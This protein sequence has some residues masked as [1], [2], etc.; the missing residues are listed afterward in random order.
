MGIL[1]YT[2][3]HIL[4]LWHQTTIFMTSH[5]LYL[6]A[7]PLYLCHHIQYIDDIT[8]T[9]FLRS[10][11]L[12]MATSYPLYMTSQ[13]WMCV[14]TP[15][16]STIKQL[17][18]IGHRTHSMYKII[19]T[20]QSNMS[21][22]YDITPHYLWHY[23]HCVHD[24]IPTISEMASTVSVSSQR[25]HWWSQTNCMYDITPTLH[26]PSY[27]LYTTSSTLYVFIPL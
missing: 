6:T 7:Y 25:L 21:S 8:P 18:Y 19:Y 26:M 22:F 24:I 9:E 12:Y 23:M 13:H 11:S 3:L 10:H 17:L 16:L 15:T 27:A 2:R 20:V 4:F 14:I 5:P 1:H